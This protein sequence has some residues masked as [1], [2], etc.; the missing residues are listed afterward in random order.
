[1]SL[2][3]P[4]YATA[5]DFKADAGM[6]STA[7][8]AAIDRALESASRAVDSTCSR[9]FGLLAAPAARTYTL[10]WSRGRCRWVASIDD[11]QDATG[12]VV[13]VNGT[14]TTDYRLTP[15]NG[16]ADGRPWT[17]LELVT[18]PSFAHL[19]APTYHHRQEATITALWGWTEVPGAVVSATL[20]QASRLFKRKDAPFGIAGS[21]ETGSELRLLAAVDPDVAVI[22]QP[23]KRRW[24]MA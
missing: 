12:L 20:L 4:V 14:V 3:A 17:G 10:T 16:P 2:W 1:M 18:T 21:P 11:V 15:L 9:Q 5:A 23:Y 24:A 8:D 6:T 13:S 19:W 7:D 22:L